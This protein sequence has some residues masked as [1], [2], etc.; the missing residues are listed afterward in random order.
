MLKGKGIT[1]FKIKR[2]CVPPTNF[3]YLIQQYQLSPYLMEIVMSRRLFSLHLYHTDA[4]L[5]QLGER[6]SAEREVTG[7][8]PGRTNTQGL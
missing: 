6:R 3:S 7:S 5:A 1:N 8:N 2:F 4:W